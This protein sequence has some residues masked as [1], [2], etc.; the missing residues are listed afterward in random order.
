M[1]LEAVWFKNGDEIDWVDPVL[2]IK[3]D[4]NDDDI[5][6]IKINNGYAWYGGLDCNEVPDDFIIRVKKEN[7]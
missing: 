6:N 2:A 4:E 5:S 1:I 3:Y 7:E